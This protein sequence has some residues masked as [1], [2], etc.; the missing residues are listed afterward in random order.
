[1]KNCLD[2]MRGLAIKYAAGEATALELKP[3]KKELVRNMKAGVKTVKPAPVRKRP[4]ASVAGAG[5]SPQSSRRR[6]VEKP[7][8]QKQGK[9]V[10]KQEKPTQQKQG[11]QAGEAAGGRAGEAAGGRAGESAGKLQKRPAA[12]QVERA[13]QD[14]EETPEEEEEE[15]DP[16]EEMCSEEDC[17]HEP[18]KR[19]TQSSLKT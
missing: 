16:E 19:Q 4:A 6:R 12:M 14:P 3:M 13:A 8:Q 15:E 1:M 2:M 5:G 11:K 7:T 18:A 17:D 9:Q 10:G